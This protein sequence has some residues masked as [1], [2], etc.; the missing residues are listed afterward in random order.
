M[1]LRSF[2]QRVSELASGTRWGVQ[3]TG[4]TSSCNHCSSVL[5]GWMDR[6][7]W[8]VFEVLAKIGQKIE[9][10]HRMKPTMV[11]LLMNQWQNILLDVA[12][13][14]ALKLPYR[15]WVVDQFS[16][17]SVKFI[18]PERFN[19]HAILP[20]NLM[21]VISYDFYDFWTLDYVQ[22]TGATF[23]QNM[24]FLMVRLW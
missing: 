14:G 19:Y 5:K 9:K 15:C 3:I 16:R 22:D 4:R 13:A 2:L 24:Q 7:G 21:W 10:W 23:I 17:L 18:C 20:W 12:L 11:E 8:K 1:R 6:T